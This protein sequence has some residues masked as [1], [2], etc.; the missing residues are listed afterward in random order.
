MHLTSN[1]KISK[2]P[3]RIGEAYRYF[4]KQQSGHRVDDQTLQEMH[5][6][7]SAGSLIGENN[8][9]QHGKSRVNVTVA[10]RKEDIGI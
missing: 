6:H 3:K 7:D 9:F 10:M 1:I 4:G 2:R 5:L 8:G